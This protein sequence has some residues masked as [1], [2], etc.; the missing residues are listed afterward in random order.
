MP[1]HTDI[2]TGERH[3]VFL[4]RDG[5]NFW[6]LAECDIV[7]LSPAGL[8]DMEISHPIPEWHLIQ[9][10]IHQVT[11]SIHVHDGDHTLSYRSPHPI[12]CDSEPAVPPA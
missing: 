5:I 12:V 4:L 2:D 8:G 1:A 10:S 9:I 3:A 11:W 6:D 7:V